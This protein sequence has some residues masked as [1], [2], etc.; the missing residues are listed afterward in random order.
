MFYIVE[1]KDQLKKLLELRKGAAYV[2]VI[3]GNYSYHPKLT[4]TLLIYETIP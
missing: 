1:S 2:E 3:P 4:S